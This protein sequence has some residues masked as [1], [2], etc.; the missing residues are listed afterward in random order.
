MAPL[1]SNDI[2]EQDYNNARQIISGV[3]SGLTQAPNQ[4]YVAPLLE[5]LQVPNEANAWLYTE[6]HNELKALL[7]STQYSAP[8]ST[9]EQE[10]DPAL[11]RGLGEAIGFLHRSLDSSIE[12]NLD[13]HLYSGLYG[14]LY[15]SCFAPIVRG[16][17]YGINTQSPNLLHC[18]ML[19]V[20]YT[21][22]ALI[23]YRWGC[24]MY[25]KKVLLMYGAMRHLLII[26]KINDKIVVTAPT[27][28]D[29]VVTGTTQAPFSFDIYEI[30]SGPNVVECAGA[31]Y[32]NDTRLKL[33]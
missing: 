7:S 4:R 18:G 11:V 26:T 13:D 23:A 29:L 2:T 22:R 27:K 24:Q 8:T 21:I 33:N 12:A 3:L 30:A 6:L 1:T 9:V 15:A 28:I 31:T 25:L 10:I 32:R 19:Y 14:Q 20:W 16:L 17:D 5:E